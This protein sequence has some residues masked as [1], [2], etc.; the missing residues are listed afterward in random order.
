MAQQSYNSKHALESLTSEAMA[1]SQHLSV[2]ECSRDAWCRAPC[3]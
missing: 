3:A 2:V 1:W